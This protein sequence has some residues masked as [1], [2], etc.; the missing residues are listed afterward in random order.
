MKLPHIVNPIRA[1]AVVVVAVVAAYVM[2]V[3]WTLI[4]ILSSPDWCARAL[5]AE[6]ASPGQTV[7]GLEACIDL[8]TVQV[9]SLA[10]DSHIAQ[11][12]VA[13]VLLTLIVIVVAG[14]KLSLTA[15]KAGVGANIGRD[16][17]GQ[18]RIDGAKEVEGAAKEKTS[19]IKHDVAEGAPPP[20]KPGGGE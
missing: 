15:S 7:K 17:V 12:V 11:G 4:D 6:K 13:M 10:I 3:G 2:W 5:G 20:M 14:G 1:F 8:M 18:A 9:K 19:E 16:D